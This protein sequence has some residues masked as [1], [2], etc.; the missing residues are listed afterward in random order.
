MYFSPRVFENISILLSNLN[1]SMD[2]YGILD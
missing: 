1:G 2:S